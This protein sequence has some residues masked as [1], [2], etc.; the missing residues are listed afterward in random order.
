MEH[1]ESS[2]SDIDN[3]ETEKAGEAENAYNAP[4]ISWFCEMCHE[5]S[6]ESMILCMPY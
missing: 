6:E 3:F 5:I 1:W 4:D 2:I